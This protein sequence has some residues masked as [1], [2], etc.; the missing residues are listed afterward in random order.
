MEQAMLGKVLDPQR[1]RIAV[2]VG[3]VFSLC[4]SCCPVTH[5]ADKADELRDPPPWCWDQMYTPPH[6]AS[7]LFMQNC[8]NNCSNR[9]L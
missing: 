1:I 7:N 2:P 8:Q 3:S 6:P 9:T 5:S 4:F